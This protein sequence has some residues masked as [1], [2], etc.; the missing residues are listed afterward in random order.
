MSDGGVS[1]GRRQ[2]LPELI[3]K[4]DIESGSMA[5]AAAAIGPV[6]G[7]GGGVKGKAKAKAPLPVDPTSQR[8]SSVPDVSHIVSVTETIACPQVSQAMSSGET[9]SRMGSGEGVTNG[10]RGKGGQAV[11]REPRPWTA[12]R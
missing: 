2:T 3:V 7:V 4:L 6:G 8:K 5:K 12:S 11:G 1:S 9:T 10:S